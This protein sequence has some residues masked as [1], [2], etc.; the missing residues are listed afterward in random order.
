MEMCIQ[1]ILLLLVI[2]A[3]LPYTSFT[4]SVKADYVTGNPSKSAKGTESIRVNFNSDCKMQA[5][6]H[7]KSYFRS[8]LLIKKPHFVQFKIK[9]Q[10]TN[11]KLFTSTDDVFKPLFWSWTFAKSSGP[12][13]FLTWNLDYG[14]LSF[15]LLDARTILMKEVYLNASDSCNITFGTPETTKQIVTALVP[16]IAVN[17]SEYPVYPMSYFCYYNVP[18]DFPS[19]HYRV[20][21]YFIF[22][23]SVIGFT[24]SVVYWNYTEKIY[25]V[26]QQ[27]SA[28]NLKGISK[29]YTI[30]LFPY[31]VGV[32]ILLFFPVVLFRIAAW[33]SVG[34]KISTE[35]NLHEMLEEFP[36]TEQAD[37]GD[38]G[39]WLYADGNSPLGVSNI[40]SFQTCGLDKKFPVFVSR[41]RRLLFVLAAPMLIYLQ[42][43]MYLQGMGVWEDR[44]KITIKNL[45]SAGV[46][47][48]FLSLFGDKE[49]RRNVFVPLLGGP[50]G[51]VTLYYCVGILFIA[52]PR[53]FKQ[54][55]E[56]GIPRSR[57]SFKSPLFYNINEIITLSM[58]NIKHHHLLPGYTKASTLLKCRF[59]C[60]F[61]GRFWKSVF[62]IQISRSASF[63]SKIELCN[64]YGLCK[65]LLLFICLSVYISL[66]LT[67]ILFCIVYYGLPFC[68]FLVIVVRGATRSVGYLARQCR[69]LQFR[70]IFLIT[71]LVVFILF[72]VFAY[73]VSLLFI[74]SFNFVIQ[75]LTYT[76]VAVIIYPSVS[77]G[78]LFVVI[79]LIY[80]LIKLIRN[81]GYKYEELLT[82]AVELS[83]RFQDESNR[84]S[85]RHGHLCISNV[86]VGILNEI[87]INGK[88]LTLSSNVL[89][90]LRSNSVTKVRLKNNAYGIPKELFSILVRKYKPV[91]VHLISLCFKAT[92]V[93]GFVVLTF[94]ACANYT[95][96]LSSEI[97]EVMHVVFVVA[98]GAVPALVEA[99]VSHSSSVT[100]REMEEREIQDSIEKYWNHLE[101]KD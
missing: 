94:I 87:S 69:I 73:I 18:K 60:L 62:D 98:L 22:P 37:N 95:E 6:E 33:L 23:I 45:V 25:D 84:V 86:N 46:P 101:Q 55:I 51:V 32:I 81:F 85:I 24:C 97:S 10:Q 59:Y 57:T 90:T 40:F 34:E 75:V 12:Y 71:C 76:F 63:W 5:T 4:D 8:Q 66:C 52:L 89:Q 88:R 19:L 47:M 43:A 1:G 44:D 21:V 15:H 91:H 100:T 48:G 92:L 16:L 58:V 79:V 96:G 7:M 53:S 49:D 68:G 29:W 3:V 50:V 30:S 61:T 14:I 35:I 65:Y 17:E 74:K 39:K 42:S 83:R 9:I 93:I 20:S 99:V 2:L 78:Y 77:F 80:Y 38:D 64:E 27:T 82:I 41:L 36:E 67:E 11:G 72:T 54:V 56:D 28:L 26:S 70:I 31:F 13:P